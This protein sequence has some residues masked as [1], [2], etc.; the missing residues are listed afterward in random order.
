MAGHIADSSFWSFVGLS[1]TFGAGPG[2]V[3]V[4]SGLGPGPGWGPYMPIWAPMGPPG[5]VL[6]DSV[7][8]VNFT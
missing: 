3:G 2:R 7:D 4:E 8:S 5:Q 6:E 1:V